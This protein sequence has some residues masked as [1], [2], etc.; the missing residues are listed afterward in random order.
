MAHRLH[1]RLSV[2]RVFRRV[3]PKCNS[4]LRQAQDARRD[5]IEIR[6]DRPCRKS[7]HVNPALPDPLIALPTMLA[8]PPAMD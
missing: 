8:A 5:S 1:I 3:R 2:F 6:Q 4:V 7:S